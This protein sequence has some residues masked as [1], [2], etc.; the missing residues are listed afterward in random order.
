MFVKPKLDILDPSFQHHST[1]FVVVSEET[2]EIDGKVI[3]NTNIVSVCDTYTKAVQLTSTSHSYKIHG[4]VPHHK[5]SI[6]DKLELPGP[7]VPKVP[8]GPRT[9]DPLGKSFF[10]SEPH[11]YHYSILDFPVEPRTLPKIDPRT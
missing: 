2:H 5:Q 8:R 3:N 11:D 9:L 10:T 1:V 4:P 7:T 6:L